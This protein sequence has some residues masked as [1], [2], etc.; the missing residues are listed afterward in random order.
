MKEF[1][2]KHYKEEEDLLSV[3]YNNKKSDLPIDFDQVYEFT[4]FSTHERFYSDDSSWGVYT[5]NSEIE[6]PTSII[7][8]DINIFSTKE[9]DKILYQ[10]TLRG[11]MQQLDPFSN[12][13]YKVK[14]KL[15]NHSKWG[16][17]F[18]VISISQ[19]TPKTVE[20]T[21]LF[22]KSILTENQTNILLEI[23]PDIVDMVI[24]NPNVDSEIDLNK[25][26][27]IKE[28]TWKIIKNKILDNYL[29]ADVL[30]L[31]SPY[32]I[33]QKRIKQL[34]N[35]EA[36]PY[37]LKEKLLNDPYIITE[38]DGIGFKTADAISLKI[39][40]SLLI[41]EQRTRG[42]VKDYLKNIGEERGDTWIYLSELDSAIK[43]NVLET[44]ILYNE[45]IE[46]EKQ[47]ETILHIE[48]DEEK[49]D[50]KVGFH[51]YYWIESEIWD[52]IIASNK[53]E[54]LWINQEHI[55]NGIKEAEKEQGFTFTEEQKQAIINMTKNNFNTLSSP[56]GCGKSTISRG[57]LKIYQKAGYSINCATLS[58]KA[59]IRLNETT[60]FP[61]QTIHRLLEA[62]PGGV[63]GRNRNLKLS[64]GVFLIDECSMINSYLFKKLFE[65]ISEN[66][67]I[68]LVG[69]NYQVSPIGYGNTFEDILKKDFLQNNKLTKI[70]RQA[71]KS[72]I[73]SDSNK[74]RQ[75]ISPFI[76]KEPK[77]VRGE[78]Q[79][80]FY[81][82]RDNR[83]SL[84][85]IAINSF[86]KSLEE[87]RSIDDIVI[88]VPRKKDVI[89]STQEINKKIQSILMKNETRFID[90]GNSKY[91][92]GDKVIH[93]K[94]NYDKNVM[95]GEMGRIISIYKNNDKQDCILVDFGDKE[96]EY[97]KRDMKELDLGY[98]LTAYKFQ[99]SQSLDVI[100]IIDN[101]HFMLLSKNYLYTAI[102]R[103]ISRCLLL[104]EPYAFDMCIK[105]DRTSTRNTWMKGF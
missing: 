41:S 19:D 80:I 6:L 7:I 29:M 60:G 66:S 49:N 48:K 50:Y 2:I 61:S 77:M 39:N 9:D 85:K 3:I 31:L 30:S 24:N 36:N 95:N 76:K 34:F 67:K 44:E 56:A 99:G 73:I 78:L 40:P 27:G 51:Y 74:I 53:E 8:N 18:E 64:E 68:I 98:S 90:Y 71:A 20:D 28:F 72:G 32:G 5:F 22:L 75:G 81:I 96:I 23:Y 87:G 69:D 91:Y 93:I 83:E 13:P 43:E 70:L 63:F 16:Y 103:S 33:S 89:N 11:K 47:H 79:D 101:T 17:G 105:T 97:T 54:P 55:D 84:N 15:S 86:M 82:F 45:F 62:R 37:L 38:I 58:A 102:T 104:A 35:E 52:K 92:F 46:S 65:A 14:A 42:F 57:I 25:L 100:T 94:N 12:V 21:G 26:N 10:V 59:A 88:L 4:G 1:K